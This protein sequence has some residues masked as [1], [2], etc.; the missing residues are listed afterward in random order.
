MK[1]KRILLNNRQSSLHSHHGQLFT[2][3]LL[4][5][6]SMT[7]NDK[8]IFSFGYSMTTVPSNDIFEQNVS[9]SSPYNSNNANNMNLQSQS[10]LSSIEAT[11]TNSNTTRTATYNGLSRHRIKMKYR[12]GNYSIPMYG[13]C[14]ICSQNELMRN[15]TAIVPNGS[16]DFLLINIQCYALHR[17]SRQGQYSFNQCNVLRNSTVPDLC[18]CTTKENITAHVESNQIITTTQTGATDVNGRTTNQAPKNNMTNQLLLV[19]THLQLEL[20]SLAKELN[21]NSITMLSTIVSRFLNEELCASKVVSSTSQKQKRKSSPN[22]K[23][24]YNFMNVSVLRQ[25]LQVETK[26]VTNIDEGFNTRKG[27]SNFLRQR[28]VVANSNS[29]D[30]S[31]KSSRVSAS[32]SDGTSA[33]N[34]PNSNFEKIETNQNKHTKWYYPLYVYVVVEGQISFDLMSESTSMLQQN[35]FS[36]RVVET[37]LRRKDIILQYLHTFTDQHKDHEQYF[38]SITDINVLEMTGENKN[39]NTTFA[40]FTN[41]NSSFTKQQQNSTFNTEGSRS[42]STSSTS[43]SLKSTRSSEDQ[44]KS[45]I[46]PIIFAI[47]C[48]VI[49]ACFVY[50]RN[51]YK[52]KNTAK[53]LSTLSSSHAIVKNNNKKTKKKNHADITNDGHECNTVHSLTNSSTTTTSSSNNNNKN[54]R[55]NNRLYEECFVPSC[56]SQII[57]RTIYAPAG[58]LGIVVDT[59]IN[60]PIVHRLF[61]SSPLV[62]QLFV[63]EYIVAVNDIDTRTMSAIGISELLFKTAFEHRKLT[64]LS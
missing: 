10:G 41:R 42:S 34:S 25:V 15:S 39:T 30:T 40:P 37:I 27:N 23:C 13:P 43:T 53:R 3:L 44:S 21:N 8:L 29:I 51:I 63:G 6:V 20:F 18:G 47:I 12:S 62:G 2:I 48:I 9:Q 5:V 56:E 49:I 17:I 45:M 55:T 16:T 61:Q 64:I 26:K 46:G 57:T 22:N 36:A 7:G 24:N 14:S 58:K 32:A 33:N 59:T 35:D 28:A 54:H 38:Q 4:V 60:G 31:T 1:R 11:L 50:C 52:E 19:S